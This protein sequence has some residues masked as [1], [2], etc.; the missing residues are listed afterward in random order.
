MDRSEDLYVFGLT[1]ALESVTDMYIPSLH[2]YGTNISQPNKNDPRAADV[3]TE[4]KKEM[5]GVPR[6]EQSQ[7]VERGY[8]AMPMCLPQASSPLNKMNDTVL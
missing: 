3:Q 1:H 6:F 8:A 5:T 2:L 7:N 4:R